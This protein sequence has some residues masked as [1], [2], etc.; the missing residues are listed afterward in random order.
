MNCLARKTEMF[1]LQV[2]CQLFKNKEIP[3][4]LPVTFFSARVVLLCSV[5][6]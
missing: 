3:V 4:K 6:I 2:L 5:P 1:K